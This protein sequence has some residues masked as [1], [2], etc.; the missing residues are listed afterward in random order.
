MLSLPSRILTPFEPKVEHA[1]KNRRFDASLREKFSYDFLNIPLNFK[2]LTRLVSILRRQTRRLVQQEVQ[3]LRDGELK[4]VVYVTT[5]GLIANY[6]GAAKEPK[7]HR[8]SAEVSGNAYVK[9]IYI[10]RRNGD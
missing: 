4:G 2:L 6:V 8:G 9:R 5:F 7:V 1:A 10:V 3:G